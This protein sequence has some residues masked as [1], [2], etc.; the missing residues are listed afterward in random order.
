V[1]AQKLMPIARAYTIHLFYDPQAVVD[2]M[3][4]H[5]DLFKCSSISPN[6]VGAAPSWTPRTYI[7][8]PRK[9][10][11]MSFDLLEMHRM[12]NH[13]VVKRHMSIREQ[14]CRMTASELL[15]FLESGE[16]P[17]VTPKEICN[18]LSVAQAPIYVYFREILN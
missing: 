13:Y 7:M 1:E 10:K 8:K 14:T 16:I 2:L 3:P 11:K 9:A 4:F 5:G 15:S 18:V 12:A 6:F 17:N